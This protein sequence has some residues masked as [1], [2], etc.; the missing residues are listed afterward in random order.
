MKASYEYTVFGRGLRINQEPIKKEEYTDKYFHVSGE[1]SLK[2]RDETFRYKKLIF[3]EDNMDVFQNISYHKSE[4]AFDDFLK[5]HGFRL[6]GST[7]LYK[8]RDL[9]RI[10]GV[11]LHSGKLEVNS[12]TIDYFTMTSEKSEYIKNL[13]K[14]MGI[15]DKNKNFMEF[16][17]EDVLEQNTR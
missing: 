2:K 8:R 6:D 14:K 7:D 3:S 1:D 11:N 17:I 15:N 12:Q 13:R 16:M 9:F 10:E 4:K 5:I